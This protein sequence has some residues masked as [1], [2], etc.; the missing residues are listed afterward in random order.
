MG[1]MMMMMTTISS[2]S[3]EGLKGFAESRKDDYPLSAKGNLSSCWLLKT[4]SVSGGKV[5][6]S[7]SLNFCQA[8]TA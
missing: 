6:S 1:L 8:L 5:L 2:F 3:S 4:L 7:A